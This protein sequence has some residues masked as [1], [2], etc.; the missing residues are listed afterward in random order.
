MVEQTRSTVN[1]GQ[2]L[3]LQMDAAARALVPCQLVDV[4]QTGHLDVSEAR[5]SGEGSALMPLYFLNVRD[6]G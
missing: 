4:N 3:I 1:A 5:R 2:I 6:R